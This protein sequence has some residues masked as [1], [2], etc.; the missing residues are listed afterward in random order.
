MAPT[1]PALVGRRLRSSGLAAAL[2]CVAGCMQEMAKQP[3]YRPLQPSAFFSDGRSARPL[4]PGTIHRD[5]QFTSG[6]QPAEQ[7]GLQRAG[8]VVA[9][10]P[11]NPLAAAAGSATTGVSGYIDAFP[12]PL[13]HKLLERG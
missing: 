10:L 7:A 8:G 11:G 5:A 4:V 1:L 12:K 9:N 6:K 2:L 13:T 3:A